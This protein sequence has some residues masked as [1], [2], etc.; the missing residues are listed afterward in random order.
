MRGCVAAVLA[1]AGAGFDEHI[2]R[3]SPHEAVVLVVG[4]FAWLAHESAG[5]D[6][7]PVAVHFLSNLA[8]HGRLEIWVVGQT[9]GSTF[10]DGQRRV[11]KGVGAPWICVRV[12]FPALDSLAGFPQ[13]REAQRRHESAGLHSCA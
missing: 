4:A 10:A 13:Q 8:A 2:V 3:A 5:P 7:P 12:A 11:V 1:F 6:E 9:P